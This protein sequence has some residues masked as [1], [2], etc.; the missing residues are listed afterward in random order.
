MKRITFYILLISIFAAFSLPGRSGSVLQNKVVID[1]RMTLEEATSGLKI[2]SPLKKSLSLVSVNYYSF[3][4]RL[5]EGQ[6]LVQSKLAGE[7]REIF[8]EIEES[9]F[10]VAKVVP[11]V[12][13][14]WS[15]SLSMSDNNT[16]AFNYR[17]VKGTKVMSAHATGRAIDI[18][19]LQNPQI[20]RGKASP[21]GAKYDIKVPGTITPS[22]PVAKAFTRRGWKWGA[23][24]RST[25][26]YQHFEKK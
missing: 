3:D 14:G 19:P 8:R 26:D 21:L 22:S 11:I 17:L 13:Y 4:G 6:V 12:K 1:S 24:W 10:P 18:N 7:I 15:D 16:S 20:K 9:R 2:P 5:H 25:K 23:T